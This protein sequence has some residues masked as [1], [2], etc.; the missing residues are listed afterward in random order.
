MCGGYALRHH[1]R[2]RG[3]CALNLS[4]YM[5]FPQVEE[6]NRAKS[7]PVS[8]RESVLPIHRPP[9]GVAKTELPAGKM[10]TSVGFEP[11][12]LARRGPEPRALDR[13]ATMS[14]MLHMT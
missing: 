10:L 3:S 2:G 1:R 4:V 8:L 6:V 12:P 9:A 14:Q 13:S 7:I 5:P 11:T